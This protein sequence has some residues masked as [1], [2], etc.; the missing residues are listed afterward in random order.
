MKKNKTVSK[1]ADLPLSNSG[2][3]K[4]E[5]LRVKIDKDLRFF[6]LCRSWRRAKGMSRYQVKYDQSKPWYLHVEFALDEGFY[7]NQSK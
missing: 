6:L 7:S 3:T 2:N 5:M 1:V 4:R